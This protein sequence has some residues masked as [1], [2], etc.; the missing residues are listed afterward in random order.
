MSFEV[1]DFFLPQKTPADGYLVKSVLHDWPDQSAVKILANL[2]AAM[3]P[4]NHLILFDII[5][6]PETDEEDQPIIPSQIKKVMCAVDLQMLVL[7]NSRERT[8]K[9]WITLFKRASDRLV[10]KSVVVLPGQPLG[11]IDAVY[12]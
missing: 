8:M 7:F 4:G 12:E 5:F 3:K 11:L 1:H 2:A 6:P 9:D 10:V